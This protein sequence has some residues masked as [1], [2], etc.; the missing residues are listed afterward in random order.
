MT[1]CIGL[2]WAVRF[3]RLIINYT[4]LPASFYH[5]MLRHCIRTN[6]LIQENQKVSNFLKNRTRKAMNFFFTKD[7]SG[8]LFSN[9]LI[10][11]R[12]FLAILSLFSL[13]SYQS[14]K[15]LDIDNSVGDL[16]VYSDDPHQDYILSISGIDLIQDKKL[17]SW[18][19][20]NGPFLRIRKVLKYEP[21]TFGPDVKY[22]KLVRVKVFGDNT[23]LISSNIIEEK[24]GVGFMLPLPRAI[25]EKYDLLGIRISVP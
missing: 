14:A 18:I 2:A 17:I 19:P 20:A 9:I 11:T 5:Q 8:S 12:V 16:V 24:E 4:I 6:F 21:K 23:E 13:S 7:Y 10:R 3:V 15:A 22:I 1:F 25:T